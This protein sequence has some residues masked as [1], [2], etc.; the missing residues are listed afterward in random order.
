VEEK[1]GRKGEC[2][3]KEL[4]IFFSVCERERERERLCVC[5]CVCECGDETTVSSRSGL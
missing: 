4:L 3:G 2:V 1:G 5:V